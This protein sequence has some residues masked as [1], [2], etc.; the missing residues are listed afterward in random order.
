VVRKMS[1]EPQRTCPSCVALE[2]ATQVAAG[3]SAVHKQRLV[4]RDIKP[5]GRFCASLW[6]QIYYNPGGYPLS[7]L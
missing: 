6:N 4:H 5:S 3:L 2:I 7:E 1:T